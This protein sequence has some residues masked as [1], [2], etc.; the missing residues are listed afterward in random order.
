MALPN[1]RP[2]A[3]QVALRPA[4]PADAIY[5]NSWRDEPSVRQ[6]QPLSTASLTQLRAELGQQQMANLHRAQGDKFQW[7]IRFEDQPAPVA[8]TASP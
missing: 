8:R 4:R 5:L 2:V 3:Q 6:F 7:I 1:E